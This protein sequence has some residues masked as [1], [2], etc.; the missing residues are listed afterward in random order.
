VRHDATKCPDFLEKR[1]ES[2]TKNRKSGRLCAPRLAD[3]NPDQ[4]MKTLLGTRVL[5]DTMKEKSVWGAEITKQWL[6]V[7][8]VGE[9]G[10]ERVEN[11]KEAIA[12]WLDRTKPVVIAFEEHERYARNLHLEMRRRKIHFFRV[13]PNELVA[14]RRSQGANVGADGINAELI[15]TFATEGLARRGMRPDI[16]RHKALGEVAARRWQIVNAL[17]TE[18]NRLAL[19]RSPTVHASLTLVIDALASSL[20]ALEAEI[21]QRD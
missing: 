6:D 20:K 3:P 21:A 17:Q 14:F 1:L 12:A 11:T 15:A 13:Y 8:L 7:S 5:E 19:A 18:R 2:K 4:R 10:I 9:A 16:G